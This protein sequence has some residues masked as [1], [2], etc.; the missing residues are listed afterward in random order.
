ME[1]VDIM[2]PVS[3]GT[4]R[5]FTICTRVQQHIAPAL[6]F[7]WGQEHCIRIGGSAGTGSWWRLRTHATEDAKKTVDSLSTPAQNEVVA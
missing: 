7:R 2:T 1:A 6:K 3:V 4:S 5:R